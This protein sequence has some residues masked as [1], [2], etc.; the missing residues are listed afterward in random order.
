MIEKKFWFMFYY[1]KLSYQISDSVRILTERVKRN[2]IQGI[3][4]YVR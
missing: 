1:C 3:Y 4:I 2:D